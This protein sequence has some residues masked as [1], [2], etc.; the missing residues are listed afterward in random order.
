MADHNVPGTD[1]IKRTK[2]DTALQ[3]YIGGTVS[4]FVFS[5]TYCNSSS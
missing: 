5:I 4:R 1:R 2:V 3:F